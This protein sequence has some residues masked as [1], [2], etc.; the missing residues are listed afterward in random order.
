MGSWS[1]LSGCDGAMRVGGLG[2]EGSAVY[3]LC[4]M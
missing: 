3:D 1:C 2:Q 4:L